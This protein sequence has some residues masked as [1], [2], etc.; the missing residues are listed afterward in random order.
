MF[1]RIII[2]FIIFTIIVSTTSYAHA[3]VVDNNYETPKQQAERLLLQDLPISM[4]IDGEHFS[5]GDTIRVGGTV[6]NGQLGNDVTL[7]V[8]NPIGN[9]V[10][11]DQIPINDLNEFYTEINASGNLWKYDGDYEIKVQY[12]NANTSENIK[13]QFQAGCCVDGFV[14][15]EWGNGSIGSPNSI[16]PCED[17]QPA[18][19]INDSCYQYSVT[20]GDGIGYVGPNQYWDS[21]GFNI[22]SFN[23]GVFSLD[24]PHEIVEGIFMVLV[25]GEEWDDVTITDEKL[26]VSYPAGTER[27]EIIG[28]KVVPEFG[29]IAMMVLM[30]SII[31]VI[32]ITRSRVGIKI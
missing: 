23:D 21:L 14:I 22:I 1:S 29:T 18:I 6:N 11:I 12:G 28:S 8:K 19:S 32:M 16:I 17:K 7:I 15:D 9:I 24:S 3:T 2:L 26:T 31:S 4:W 30:V 20:E 25:D 5:A 10:T 13:I 27:I